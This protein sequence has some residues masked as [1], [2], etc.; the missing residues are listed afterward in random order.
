MITAPFNFVPLSEEV[1]F[2]DWAQDVSHDIPFEDSQSGAIEI[3]LTAKSPIFVRDSKDEARFCHH[4]GEHYIPST[5]VKGMI[6]SI[7]EI[8]SFSK[9][10]TGSF[11]DTTYSIRDLSD[12]NNFYMREMRKDTFCGWMRKDGNDYIIEDCAKPGRIK[13]EEIDTIFG[14]DF[15]SKFKKGTFANKADSKTAL[16]KYAMIKSDTFTYPFKHTTTSTIGDKRYSLDKT[17]SLVGTVVFTGQPSGRDESKKIPSGKVYEFIFFEKKEDIVLEKKIVENFLFAYF[18]ERETQPT[19]SPDWT[20]WKKKLNNGEKVPV[21]FQKSGKKI[22]HFGLSYLYKLP[23]AYSVKDG[24]PE[25]HTD[26]RYDLAQT[27][28]GYVK[29]KKALRGRVHFSHFKATSNVQELGSTTEIL[30][31]PRASYFPIYV[32]QKDGN[33]YTTF[34][35]ASFALAGRK[36]YPIHASN[37]T[38]KTTDTGNENVGTK[39]SPLKDGVVFKGKLKYH[40][41]KKSELGAV[42]SALT[43]HNTQGCFHNIG[44]AKA[45]GYGKVKLTIDNLPKIEEYLK[46]FEV[47]MSQN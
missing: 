29:G 12:S 34:M 1:F 25:T 17:S 33:L 22:K 35:D 26:D 7:V 23:Y 18:D 11:N 39:F 41:L 8:L 24:I 31:T 20:Y 44:M 47:Q 6:R 36:R 3:T 43:F 9:I 21:F 4:Q 38:V 42:L 16:K 46:E 27:V 40:N 14:I 13:H 28:F 37:N 32:Q 15:A 30:G 10:E 5:S 45:L 19:E 2:P